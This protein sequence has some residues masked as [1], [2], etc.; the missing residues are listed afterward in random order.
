MGEWKQELASPTYGLAFMGLDIYSR[1]EE[2]YTELVW[3]PGID[4][5]L[6][7][8]VNVAKRGGFFAG[9]EVGTL[10]FL[11]PEKAS[12]FTDN[13][14]GV[15]EYTVNIDTIMAMVFLMA[16]YGYRLELGMAL[17]GVSVGWEMGIG[18][19]LAQGYLGLETHLDDGAGIESW[20]SKEFYGDG[21]GL[22]VILDTALEAAIRLG[23]N[24]R[25][26]A[27]LGAMLTPPVF[28]SGDSEGHFWDLLGTATYNDAADLTDRYQ[29]DTAPIIP[30]IRVGFILNY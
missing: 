2:G 17:G 24:F 20:G 8:G 14:P 29:V 28:T 18:A 23:K 12:S 21:M 1:D 9:A 30:T 22:G 19:R 13:Y 7:R 27:R 5:R 10:F 16:K 25:I 15:E 4:L 26:F 11:T 3:L 6:F